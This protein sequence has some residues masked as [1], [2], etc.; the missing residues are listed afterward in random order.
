MIEFELPLAFAA[1]PLPALIYFLMPTAKLNHTSLLKVPFYQDL[2]SFQFSGAANPVQKPIKL[3]L[4]LS[5]WILLLIASARPIWLGEEII[6]PA[7]GRDL[8][9][10]VD[11]SESMRIPDMKI[12][13]ESV[14]RLSIIKLVLKDFIARRSGDRLGLILFGTNAY[15]QTPLTFDQRT[16]EQFLLEAEI[17]IAGQATAIGD[18]IGLAI[19]RLQDHPKNSRVLILLTDGSNTAGNVEPLQAAKLAKEKSLK[20]YTVGIGADEM[21]AQG[22]FGSPFFKQ[23]INPSADLDEKTLTAIAEATGGQYFRAKTAQDLAN[24]YQKLDA[25]EKIES[26]YLTFRPKRSLFFWFLGSAFTLSLTYAALFLLTQ[27]FYRYKNNQELSLTQ[28]GLTG[29]RLSE[30]KLRENKEGR[31]A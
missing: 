26:D 20:I 21:E 19:K 24:I 7:E 13:G 12:N 16:L 29:S 10:A 25:L 14:D 18:A 4:L 5:I 22:F 8:M 11:V 6:V 23:T 17:G 2:Q 9:L 27:Y 15:L 30:D 3:F 31:D 28:D 1:L